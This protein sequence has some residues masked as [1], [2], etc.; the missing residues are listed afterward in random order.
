MFLLNQNA[1]RIIYITVHKDTRIKISLSVGIK[2]CEITLK[3]SM[4]WNI[5][6]KSWIEN[7]DFISVWV[8]QNGQL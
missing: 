1:S 7:E 8:L 6:K 2:L 5:D 3:I 4:F